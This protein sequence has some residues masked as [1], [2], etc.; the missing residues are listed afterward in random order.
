M[1]YQLPPV[2]N[3]IHLSHTVRNENVSQIFGDA[4]QPRFFA[5]GTAALAAAITAAIQLKVVDEP[6]VI[7]PAYSCP[8]LISAII[9]AGAKPVLVDFE[10]DTPWMSLKLLPT[11]ITTNTVAVIAVNLFG[12]SERLAPLRQLTKQADILLI[13]DSAQAFPSASEQGVWQGDLV[14][15]SFGRGKPVSLLGGGA[16][17]Y[18]EKNSRCIDFASLLP[19]GVTPSSVNVQNRVSFWLKAK[20]YNWMIRPRLYWL[21]QNLPFLHL[22]ETRYSPLDS[23]E[24]MDQVK[25]SM[26][27]TNIKTYQDNSF[28]A[29][30]NLAA[31]L[32][33][34]DLKG[35]GIIDLA[36]ACKTVETRRLLRYPLLVEPKARDHLYSQLQ[37]LGLGPSRM[38]PK[39]LP[40]ISGVDTLL[41]TH[42]A[43]P[44]ALSFSK[45]ILTLPTHMQV[46]QADIDKIQQLISRYQGEI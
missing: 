39:T 46:K 9:F 21:P 33:E 29:Q 36:K 1:F 45:R 13:E 14:V 10:A 25:L 30:K 3:P 40:E 8:D 42:D 4:Y 16:V 11:K 26:L 38:Y 37:Q 5:S 17:L 27:T 15:L 34:C 43:F 31:M 6:E 24:G 19:T 12:I 32:N 18:N 7:L 2:G 23:I 28:S 22:G 44:A 20:L 41:S 35:C